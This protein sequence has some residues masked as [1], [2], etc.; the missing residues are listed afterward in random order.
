MTYRLYRAWPVWLGFGL[1][2][3]L[4]LSGFWPHTPLHAVAT[5]HVEKFA[6][7]TGPVDDGVEAVYFLDFLTGTLKCAVLSNQT[8]NFQAIYTAN[9]YGDLAEVIKLKNLEIDTA[10]KAMQRGGG[11]MRPRIEIPQN[12]SYMLVTGLID[13][14]RGAAVRLRPGLAAVY[15]AETNTGIVLAYVVPWSPDDHNTNRPVSAPM[16]LWAG[17][18]FTTAVI[19]TP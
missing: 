1:L 16:T 5:D 7:A 17:E 3:G 9:I 8:R 6:I 2:V 15:V 12:P 11:G 13:I 18:Q 10:N 19:R 14:R 4:A